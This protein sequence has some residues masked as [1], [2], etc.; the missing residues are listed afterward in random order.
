MKKLMIIKNI[1]TILT[2][3]FITGCRLAKDYQQPEL[4]LPQQFE[5]V[6][7]ADTSSIADLEW[8]RF[9][10]DSSLQGLIQ[11]G[12]V[13]NHDL[14]IATKRLDIA[15]QQVKQSKFLQQPAI[16][17]QVG[18]QFTHFSENSLTGA[19]IS[20]IKGSNHIENYVAGATL[21]W[22]ADIWGKIRGQKET[23][24][25]Q[26]LQTREAV[27]A[28][29]TQL[30]ANISEGYFNLL[31][32]DEQMDIA[33]KN[34]ALNENFLAATRLLKDAGNVTQLA[35][36]Q[37]ESQKLTTSLLI[38]Q[39]EQDITLQENALQILTGQLPGT[40]KHRATLKEFTVPLE[41][42]TGLPVAMVSRRPD[43]R[44]LEM[45]LVKANAQVGV[46]Q[47]SM[48]PA[49]NI[50]AGAGL[51]TFT[52]SNWFNMPGSLFGIVAGSLTQPVFNRRQL[53]TNFE[54]A[55]LEREQAV[56]QFRQAVLKATGEVMNALT[57]ADKLKEQE[58]IANS[59]TD[60]LRKAVDNAQL[61]FKS[62]MANY[63][64]VI[65]AQS[66]ALQAELNLALVQRGR[67]NAG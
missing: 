10:T 22:E 3:V 2:L 18:G 11:K 43:V 24:L 28:V 8:N 49:L 34:L 32:L 33:K 66:N 16:N 23:T 51:E 55:K 20:N 9:F 65:T 46:A 57:Q 5:T 47:A 30:V 40:I 4:Q 48:Y 17:L 26:Y 12:L 58:L 41:L 59:Q 15:Q 67:L 53:K 38:P 6:S 39:L 62:D 60:T 42:P 14:L 56:I 19:N 54:V 44:A 1:A 61:L 37:A 64:E 52:A 27:K 35:V 7:F 63:L 31:M 21:S 45:G 36:Q 50:T 29:Q 25:A 13:Y